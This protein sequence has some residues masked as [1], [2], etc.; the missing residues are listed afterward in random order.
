MTC[1]AGRKRWQ[2]G[3]TCNLKLVFRKIVQGYGG[4]LQWDSFWKKGDE[5]TNK[6]KKKNNARYDRST[7]T[8][9][10]DW[11]SSILSCFTPSGTREWKQEKTRRCS[12]E[13]KGR[14]ERIKIRTITHQHISRSKESCKGKKSSLFYDSFLACCTDGYPV[15]FALV[16]V[17]SLFLASSMVA[18]KEAKVDL[19]KYRSKCAGLWIPDGVER[20]SKWWKYEKNCF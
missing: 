9:V 15:Q 20:W 6:I 3:E 12:K 4:T 11:I 2:Q 5:T 7:M 10:H 14:K 13:K 17:R 1:L 8:T 19:R 18:K 16:L